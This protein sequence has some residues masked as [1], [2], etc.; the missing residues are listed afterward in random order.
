MIGHIDT[1]LAEPT[2]ASLVSRQLQ[3]NS[4]ELRG[5]LLDLERDGQ[6]RWN[7]VEAITPTV[8]SDSSASPLSLIAPDVQISRASIAIRNRG[9]VPKAIRDGIVSDYLNETLSVDYARFVV[10]WEG[11]TRQLDVLD[12]VGSIPARNLVVRHFQSQA[13][14]ENGQVSLN[15]FLLTTSGS[16]IE[17]SGS[18]DA[19]ESDSAFVA[20]KAFDLDV[21]ATP[22]SNAELSR[23]IPGVPSRDAVV[24]EVH[25]SGDR[26]EL[27]INN[28]SIAR[29]QS[30]IQA[31]GVID[32]RQ[33]SV[34]ADIG[35]NSPRVTIAD[36][37]AILNARSLDR[38]APTDSLRGEVWIQASAP[39]QNLND[40]SASIQSDLETSGGAISASGTLSLVDF[41]VETYTGTIAMAEIDLSTLSGRQFPESN[42]NGSVEFSVAGTTPT[43]MNGQVI[44]NLGNSAFAGV[45]IDTLTSNLVANAG[46]FYL[47]ANYTQ[48]GTG[49]A[50]MQGTYD[51]A[52]LTPRFSANIAS[53]DIDLFSFG[54]ESSS[55]SQFNGRVELRG[56]G[57]S[58]SNLQ[59]VLL[60]DADSSTVSTADRSKQLKP[61]RSE[62]ELEQDPNAGAKLTLTG[63]PVR[64]TF[65]S[66][67]TIDQFALDG[68]RWIDLL[69]GYRSRLADKPYAM[70]R[71]GAVLSD[72][73]AATGIG[74]PTTPTNVIESQ[75]S[76]LIE[77]S[78]PEL[79]SAIA[80][81]GGTAAGLRIEGGGT[82]SSASILL[83]SKIVADAFRLE[84]VA[85]DSFHA[86]FT[87]GASTVPSINRSFLIDASATSGSLSIG[88]QTINQ[89]SL[90]VRHREGT[91][92]YRLQSAHGERLG[93]IDLRAQLTTAGTSTRLIIDAAR[94]TAGDYQIGV[95][96]PNFVDFYSDAVVARRLEF[97]SNSRSG[98]QQRLELDGAFSSES[99]DTLHVRSE[100][101]ALEQLS[102]FFALRK[103]IGGVLNGHAAIT[104]R[105][106]R[107][108]ISG[109]ADVA[110]LSM[111]ERV[112]G[113]VVASAQFIPGTSNVSVDA[114]IRPTP[115]DYVAP[116]GM[117][118]RRND[119]D[120]NGTLSF[121]NESAGP[122]LDLA[123]DITRADLFFFEYV[124]PHTIEDVE[125]LV[126][127][128]GT[129]RGSWF[130]PVFGADLQIAES[131]FSVPD[132]DLAYN[133]DGDVTVDRVGI[134]IQEA[135]VTDSTGG[136]AV[137]SGSV[138]FNDYRFF[139]LDLRGALNEVQVMNVDQSNTLPFFGH[140]WASGDVSLSGPISDASLRSVNAVTTPNSVLSIPL[141]AATSRSDAAFIVFADSSGVVQEDSNRRTRQNV[142]D[143][144]PVGERTFL[145]GLDMDLNVFGPQGSTVNLVIDPLLGDVMN[146]VGTG[147]VQ[148]IRR[149]GEFTTFGTFE[150]NSGDYLFTAGDVFVRR[151]AIDS[152]GSLTWD[153]DPTNAI[154]DVPASYRTR[155]SAAGLPGAELQ[156][157]TIPLIVRLQITGRVETPEVNLS[158]EIDRTNRNVSG[159][160]Q[161]IEAI[162]N[163]PARATEY[164]T[165]VLV[166]NSF[167]LTTS[168]ASSNAIASS[169]FNS[170]SQLVA[171]QINRYLNEAL[172]NVDFSFGVQGESAQELG[173]TY[174]IALSLLDERLVIR[175]RG[176][177]QGNRAD[178]LQNTG[179]QGLEGEFVVE[180]RLSET[181]SVEAFYRREGDVLTET[182]TT[183]GST[184][185]GVSYQTEFSSWRHFFK[186]IFG[187]RNST[188]GATA[189]SDTK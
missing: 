143:S 47:D 43:D 159:S 126:R 153:G 138:L 186:R 11:D 75:F 41:L 89:P 173:V 113:D 158:L 141:V 121:T 128:N 86:S 12:V 59:G 185:A 109:D 16:R 151:F 171:S 147:R 100:N 106:E 125:G 105:G 175:G 24:L 51:L 2:W 71:A 36:A 123:V 187:N 144:R 152:G 6:D 7:I 182:A 166:T 8:P 58:L 28:A 87:M 35:L 72:S 63:T 101:I 29:G 60:V 81:K 88:R 104:R 37:Q 111:G 50:R 40:L 139:S 129:I 97:F 3:L 48:P 32:I 92:T 161:A 31:A 26:N 74:S 184:G 45:P 179:G 134:H 131:S 57:S 53:T 108:I 169:A 142:L 10:D 77:A 90:T 1:V 145:D 27:V 42:L 39:R 95:S 20:T 174:G 19:R 94:L 83:S 49:R 82:L 133:L 155:A 22:L 65:S 91:G 163:Q 18:Y 38:Y 157:G 44:V 136:S 52:L 117:V 33:D 46:S 140:I 5:V 56:S 85:A 156:G 137:L 76:F 170:V 124:F 110:H 70:R 180:L 167:L 25:A 119:L 84:S 68:E 188:E 13:I 116:A 176:V 9:S 150:V 64:G 189:S 62:I 23:F 177:Y 114:Q 112:L 181:V 103:T 4:V 118:I 66:E 172:P 149:E 67:S 98:T 146:S 54:P 21:R 178:A 127:G 107:S 55:R 102:N 80:G 122:N 168:D 148:I 130:K 79:L 115:D 69:E 61:F 154:L 30:A 135:T 93:P 78:D 73:A 162:L 120:L 165:S 160:Y 96:A 14:I 15:E 34:V 99:T 164:A 132:F 183:T 17:I